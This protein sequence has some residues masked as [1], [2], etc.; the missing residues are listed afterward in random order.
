MQAEHC[1]DATWLF[2]FSAPADVPRVSLFRTVRGD[3]TSSVQL[4]R[5]PTT[6]EHCSWVAL[7]QLQLLAL[8]MQV[9]PQMRPPSAARCGT[10]S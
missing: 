6:G 5:M 10:Q 9:L 7:L 3:G 8:L 2:I 1:S 4:V